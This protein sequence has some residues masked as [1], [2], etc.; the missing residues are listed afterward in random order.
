MIN[1]F[2][3]KWGIKYDSR[4]TN[5]LYNMLKTHC[6]VDFNLTCITD[7]P[8]GIRQEVNIIDYNTFD[9][10]I[11]PKDRIFTREKVVL[12]KKYQTDNN[13]WI[14]Q[15]IIIHNNIT[16][17]LTRQMNK[18]TFIWNYWN[19]DKA[20]EQE[21]L[22]WFGT[23][24]QC[25]V[26]SSFVGWTGNAGEFIYDHLNKNQTIAFHTYKSLDKYLFYQHWRND[27]L[28]FW[29]KEHWYNYNFSE[30][31]FTK[32]EDMKG[33]IFNTSH[34]KANNIQ[35]IVAYEIHEADGWAKDLWENYA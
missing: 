30:P 25:F 28:C 12:F 3:F 20:S 21:S 34:I 32:C 22:K 8:D 31:P 33:C 6:D 7:N 18:P 2:T 4:Y 35:N 5:R 11:Q 13:F 27:N 16:E 1:I 29:E 23:G 19:W 14:D 24:T 10:W 15:D 26:N 17:L 9:P